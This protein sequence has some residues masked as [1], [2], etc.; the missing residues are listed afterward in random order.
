M[1][2]H[3]HRFRLEK[4]NHFCIK[5]SELTKDNGAQSDFFITLDKKKYGVVFFK[6]Q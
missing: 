6:N 2:S 4:K 1:F 3:F 5:L